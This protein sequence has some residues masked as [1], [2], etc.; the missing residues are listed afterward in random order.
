MDRNYISL[1]GYYGIFY[2]QLK[3]A[4][5]RMLKMFP[6]L[7][8]AKINRC[9]VRLKTSYYGSNDSLTM[10]KEIRVLKRRSDINI[11]DLCMESL[12]EIDNLHDV[13]DGVY[14]LVVIGSKD[15]YGEYDISHYELKVFEGTKYE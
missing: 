3:R 7:L 4:I 6:Q 12:E 2:N 11:S 14:E 15:Y 9:V 1:K 5:R 10:K 8:S 13:D